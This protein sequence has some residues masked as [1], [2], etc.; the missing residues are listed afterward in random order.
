MQLGC[1]WAISI[2]FGAS[3]SSQDFTRPL[4]AWSITTRQLFWKEMCEF[5][6]C[7]AVSSDTL[8]FMPNPFISWICN[9]ILLCTKKVTFSK[10]QYIFQNNNYFSFPQ[11]AALCH[12]NLWQDSAGIYIVLSSIMVVCQTCYS[13]TDYVRVMGL[14]S[15]TL[16]MFGSFSIYYFLLTISKNRSN[17]PSGKYNNPLLSKMSILGVNPLQAA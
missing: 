2:C 4:S 12:E 6:Q 16:R 14:A 8:S 5:Y 11:K 3:P 7:V 15:C 10:K 9:I 1:T 13:F 17:Q